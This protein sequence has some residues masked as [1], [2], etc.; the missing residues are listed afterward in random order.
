M[1]VTIALLSHIV[2]MVE[3]VV[4]L[5]ESPSQPAE[6]GP[7]TVAALAGI[8]T[9]CTCM[10]HIMQQSSRS[11]S[12]ACAITGPHEHDSLSIF[13]VE[14]R[15]YEPQHQRSQQGTLEGLPQSPEGWP[16]VSVG[17]RGCQ[18]DGAASASK[19]TI[20]ISARRLDTSAY[21]GRK[22]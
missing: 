20:A 9:L 19:T 5:A 22:A 13:C 17:A 14:T 15:L 4:R 16:P 2:I 3:S 12:G 21:K 1:D 11:N 7:F 8:N 6:P 18:C 10:L